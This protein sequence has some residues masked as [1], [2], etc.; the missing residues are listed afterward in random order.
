MRL[1]INGALAVLD[2]A[3]TVL[4]H[5]A[6]TGGLRWHRMRVVTYSSSRTKLLHRNLP[7]PSEILLAKRYFTPRQVRETLWLRALGTLS[8]RGSALMR[9]AKI[10]T[11]LVLLPNTWLT[12]R[13][14]ER[15]VDQTMRHS[16]HPPIPLR[17]RT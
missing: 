7:V 14:R 4:H 17:S 2:P 15:I 10:V 11:G 3:T 16:I 9:C 5:H 12:M 13:S 1:Y 6:S 8:F